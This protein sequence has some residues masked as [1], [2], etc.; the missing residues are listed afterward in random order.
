MGEVWAG[1]HRQLGVPVAIKFLTAAGLREADF[2]RAFRT[3]VRAIAALDHPAIVTTYD[4]GEVGDDTATATAG[5]IPAGSPWLAME[6]VGGG[7][8]AP[9]V[10]RLT[11]PE[12]R[13]VLSGLLD[14]L[15]HAHARSVVHR[16]LKPGNVLVLDEE[17]ANQPLSVKLTDFG[18]AQAVDE[19]GDVDVP[20]AG[21]TPS[22]MAPEQFEARWRDTGP[23]SDLYALG[24][25]AWA[26]VTGT[27][28]FGRGADARRQH[29][30][31][32]PPPLR[33]TC[34]VPAGLEP[35][36]RRLLEKEPARR[37]RRAADAR[38]AFAALGPATI[39]PR[40]VPVGPQAEVDTLVLSPGPEVGQLA[41]VPTLTLDEEADA[42]VHL[43][44]GA[45]ATECVP[46]SPTWRGP[47]ASTP[48]SPM[49]LGLFGLRPVPLV[50]R[51]TERDALWSSLVRTAHTG[52]AHAV[53]LR[54][55]PGVGKTRLARWL[56]ERAHETGAAIAMWGHHR[57]VAG[58]DQGLGAMLRSY[59][60]CHGLDRPRIHDRIAALYRAQGV[61]HRDEWHAL[62]EVLAPAGEDVSAEV[63]FGTPTERYVTV[64][65]L[66][67]RVCSERPVVIV[68]DD[69]QYGL[70]ALHFADYLLGYRPR[71][72]LPIL[73]VL[74]LD[75]HALAGQLDAATSVE[76]LLARDRCVSLALGPLPPAHRPALIRGI[77]GLEPELASRV[78]AQT[79]GNPLFAVELVGDWVQEGLLAPSP[80]G[81]RARRPLELPADVD[82]MWDQRV[83]RFVS[84]L[85]AGETRALELAAVLG[86]DVD[87]EEWVNA[88]A[89][90]ELAVPSD[91]LVR[92]L[93]HRGLA[94]SRPSGHRG[95]SFAHLSL[96]E[97]VVR[98]ARAGGRLSVWH[99]LVAQLLEDS[100]R[101]LPTWPL[102][103]AERVGRHW[104]GAGRPVSA[105]SHLLDGIQ[106]RRQ[107]GDYAG[108]LRLVDAYEEALR[109]GSVPDDDPRWGLGWVQR[110]EIAYRQ[111]AH[112]D[113]ERWLEVTRQEA[114]R[115]GWHD[116]LR[117]TRY[118]E[119]HTLR[120][121]GDY[122]RAMRQLQQ[123][124]KDAAKAGDRELM[125]RCRREAG[126]TLLESGDVAGGEHWLRQALAEYRSL[127]DDVGCAETWRRLGDA[128]KERGNYDEARDLLRQAEQQLA[129]VG[130]RYGTAAA[131][132]SR[133]EVARAMGDL[134]TAAQLYRRSRGLFKAIGS[135]LWIFPEYN[136]ALV[137]IERGELERAQPIL[138]LSLRRFED[139]KH[140]PAVAHAH[141]ALAAC[142]AHRGRW[143]RW[144]AHVHDARVV[145]GRT[146]YADEDTARMAFRA[147]QG[148]SRAGK[149][150]RARN[151][152]SLSRSL[153]RILDRPA[154]LKK[155]ERLLHGLDVP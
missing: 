112:R 4:F 103:L 31:R 63:R 67:Q 73:L 35:W 39:A 58:P 75:D 113:G 5:R 142:E 98:R 129:A 41:E 114:K 1:V 107:V 33:P 38:F 65:R 133:G 122:D 119:A 2:V 99:T 138:Q 47:G 59:L 17:L 125:A 91:D 60:R 154:E 18:L 95:W 55:A 25:L 69:A 146:G 121:E 152:W 124:E 54:G 88:C 68:L 53:V 130:H 110:Y 43:P 27:P 90:A 61:E 7:T 52:S 6:R 141:L 70:D 56:S 37:F 96:Q 153:W 144:D 9:L 3:E 128:L 117:R 126:E 149:S 74:T 66:L 64:R 13:S 21:G 84:H 16:D 40:A 34:H 50:D 97:A 111:G 71:G 46:L 22:Y 109:T 45:A 10:G 120:V 83:D 82:A 151:A 102:G 20:F 147:A 132:N 28:P 148:A 150:D 78:D 143:D 94:V 104:L 115:H 23:W 139:A 85:T 135:H 123:V 29:L 32:T 72:P 89:R 48:P 8:L 80:E 105:L 92:Q 62:T 131:M 81:I 12:V 49:G 137:H 127:G 44:L 93:L 26:L 101:R 36:L 134:R 42:A 14:A 30:H 116:L 15:A 51:L 155:V 145:L 87:R 100:V 19:R 140:Q 24:A 76:E 57:A 11:W 79:R 118:H 106:E 86:V 108:A 136:G 77:L